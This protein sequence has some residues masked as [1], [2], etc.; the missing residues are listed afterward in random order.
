MSRKSSSIH[1][2]K[3]NSKGLNVKFEK[4]E[5]RT[6]VWVAYLNVLAQQRML[7]LQTGQQSGSQAFA[8][9]GLHLAK[10]EKLKTENSRRRH[11][12]PSTV[13]LASTSSPFRACSSSSRASPRCLHRNKNQAEEDKQRCLPNRKR[14]KDAKRLVLRARWGQTGVI[15]GHPSLPASRQCWHSMPHTS[16]TINSEE[17][18]DPLRPS[19][20][21]QSSQ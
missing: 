18:S 4:V 16:K 12:L 10:V 8:E 11:P 1:G 21:P 19:Q 9:L 7:V 14:L 6:A 3:R 13:L 15:A 20:T 5:T 17:L 2:V